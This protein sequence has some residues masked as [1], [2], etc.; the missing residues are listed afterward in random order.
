MGVRYNVLQGVALRPERA[1][2]HP[3]LPPT[4]ALGRRVEHDGERG[5]KLRIPHQR[6]LRVALRRHARHAEADVGIDA[7]GREPCTQ[8]FRE[9]VARLRGVVNRSWHGEIAGKGQGRVRAEH[10]RERMRLLLD[11]EDGLVEG[12]DGGEAAHLRRAV[13]WVL[14]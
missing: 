11:V 7:H 5:L 12:V 6:A 13:L 9:V 14:V 3:Q 2:Q 1:A 10:M 4:H 8:H